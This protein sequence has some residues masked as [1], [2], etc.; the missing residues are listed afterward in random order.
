MVSS[1]A[2]YLTLGEKIPK[3]WD[4]ALRRNGQLAVD[5]IRAIQEWHLEGRS[6]PDA[7]EHGMGFSSILD[8]ESVR[9]RENS[10]M[11]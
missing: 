11:P 10:V 9:T 8:T 3:H 1:I 2:R 7:R 6:I 5:I 4:G